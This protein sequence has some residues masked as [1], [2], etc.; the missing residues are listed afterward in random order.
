M[1]KILIVEDE[2]ALAELYKTVF[3]EAGYLAEIAG[4]GNTALTKADEQ[5]DLILL[6]VMLP[7]LNGI[8][9]IHKLKA[10][11]RTRTIPILVISNLGQDDIIKQAKKLGVSD[12]LIKMRVD[13][14]EILKK[15]ELIL[16]DE[17]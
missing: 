12:Y 5:P 10:D 17:S 9:V 4:D 3:L 15:A 1:K 2:I 13:P 8:D 14:G 11:S 7:Q 6:D 16:A